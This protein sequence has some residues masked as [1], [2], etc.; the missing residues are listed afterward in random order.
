MYCLENDKK[1]MSVYA[2]YRCRHPMSNYIALAINNITFFSNV[3]DL[4]Q[5]LDVE[6]VDT[7][8]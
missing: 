7:E 1:K 6:P 5:S 2:C 3:F 8:G 4:V